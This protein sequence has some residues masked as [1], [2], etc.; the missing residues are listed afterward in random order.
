VR[1]QSEKRSA[2]P[3]GTWE[4]IDEAA[5]LWSYDRRN[6]AGWSVR[7]TALRLGDGGV[8]AVSPLRGLGDEAHEG[9]APLG[10]PSLLLAPN[11][12]HHLGLA[13]WSGRYGAR[14]LSSEAAARRLARKT[15]VALGSG[16]ELRERLPRGASL[17]VPAG[18]K[19]GEVWL[20][21]EGADGVAWVVGDAF[22]TMERTPRGGM[23]L[24]LRL[25]GTTPG[26]RIGGTFTMLGVGERARDRDWLKEAIEADRPRAL[27]PGH[28]E[29]LRG[30]DLADRLREVTVRRLG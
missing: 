25:T 24:V 5:G 27:V 12:F 30:A 4:V 13:E 22:F 29:V 19:N 23:G 16:E 17:L 14:A 9:L 7:T 11:H 18:L 21:V 20:R 3:G 2:G 8:V 10:K 26:L 6:A 28:G 15:E 1:E